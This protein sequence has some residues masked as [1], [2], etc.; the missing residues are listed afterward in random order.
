MP[1]ERGT[2][3]IGGILKLDTWQ[4]VLQWVCYA[5]MSVTSE[6]HRETAFRIAENER[7]REVWDVQEALRC[8]GAPMK[9]NAQPWTRETIRLLRAALTQAKVSEFRI[10]E[11]ERLRKAFDEWR[12]MLIPQS[13]DACMR[14]TARLPELLQDAM[15]KSE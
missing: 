14:H 15:E 5:S 10:V 9:P 4:K 11:N 8:A 12:S 2:R 6:E 13:L 1:Y 3:C 7:L